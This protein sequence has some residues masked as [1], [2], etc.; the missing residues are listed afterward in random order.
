MCYVDHIERLDEVLACM[1]RAGLK[2]KPSKREILKDSI[3]YIGRMV[4]N[5]GIRADPD[6]LEAVSS[7]RSPK[8]EHQLL[9]FLDLAKNY[10]TYQMLSGHC[11]PYPR[12]HETQEQEIHV[13]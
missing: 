8:I 5:Y 4:D 10:R 11:I 7:L 6:A 3:R 2:C 9:S 12:T 13:E 1:K